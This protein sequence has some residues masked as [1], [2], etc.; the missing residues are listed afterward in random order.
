[1]DTI[2]DGS[3]QNHYTTGTGHRRKRSRRGPVHL[4]E[5]PHGARIRYAAESEAALAEIER[6]LK[7]LEARE[8]RHEVL[9]RT[10]ESQQRSYTTA[11]AAQAHILDPAAFL[12]EVPL[13]QP[14]PGQRKLADILAV[15]EAR[16]GGRSIE[17]TRGGVV[18]DG[19][20]M[21]K[22]M[23]L[24]LRWLDDT[25]QRVR[26]GKPRFGQPTMI[27]VPKIL[28]PQWERE[29]RRTCSSL[30]L[31]FETITTTL[32]ER[33]KAAVL[34]VDCDYIRSCVDIVLTTYD[35]LKT[36][37]RGEADNVWGGLFS[38]H[39]RRL[40]VDE[41]ALLANERTQV[42]GVCAAI[43]ADC[44]LFVT[45][46]PFPSMLAKDV[47]A[48][49]SFLHCPVR[50]ERGLEEETELFCRVLKH[51]YLH[52]APIDPPQSPNVVWLAFADPDER[53]R[54]R[55]LETVIQLQKKKLSR[56]TIRS[57]LFAPFDRATGKL[58]L[59][60][61][62]LLDESA[63]A[64]SATAAA[65]AGDG[66]EQQ[67]HFANMTI[68]RKACFSL[69]L[70]L[71]ASEREEWRRV[72]GPSTRVKAILDYV[73][74]YQPRRDKSLLF[75]EWVQPLEEVAH[76]LRRYGISYV[77]LQHKLSAR[78]RTQLLAA[79]SDPRSDHPRVT[80]MPLKLGG[81]GLDCLQLAINHLLMGAT[82][83]PAPE[84]QGVGRIKRPGQKKR[85]HFT[86]FVLFDT[87]EDRMQEGVRIKEIRHAGMMHLVDKN[88]S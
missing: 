12:R 3:V 87:V 6:E 23:G 11:Q 1:M 54:Y 45:A 10:R 2:E 49:L 21:G 52:G 25:Q 9:E 42:F 34:H 19:T 26:E 82:W 40:V 15:V 69:A 47:N 28:V 44:R 14:W 53:A 78:E 33:A 86:K 51:L 66:K 37:A 73:C 4:P 83:A 43:K 18:A 56:P 50:F 64:L 30:A 85:V 27:V 84:I 75:D 59:S 22:S 55:A 24:I 76:W 5:G 46:T 72:H 65:A 74:H 81:A 35:T 77:L 13:R 48:V 68:L 71:P 39:Y 67:H 32:H 29:F 60:F 31:T 38:I 7:E 63:V 88:N 41:S 17:E 70:L 20:G 79:A 62:S 57:I 36:G 80:L 16:S 61:A 58:S 8:A